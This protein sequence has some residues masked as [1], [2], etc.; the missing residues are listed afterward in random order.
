MISKSLEGILVSD[1]DTLSGALRFKG[2]R[3]HAKLLF[4]YVL[5]GGTV[6]EFLENYPEVSREQADAVLEWE[7]SRIADEF[8]LEKA[9]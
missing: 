8:A 2:T 4:D 9:S 5:T 3:I 1:S 6:E 7:R